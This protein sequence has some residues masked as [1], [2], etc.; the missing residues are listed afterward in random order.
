MEEFLKSEKKKTQTK[1][2][3]MTKHSFYLLRERKEKS[4]PRATY[5][6]VPGGTKT[7]PSRVGFTMSSPDK[8]GRS[9]PTDQDTEINKT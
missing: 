7:G 4:L 9:K 8:S 5:L 3:E 6:L 2:N 1:V